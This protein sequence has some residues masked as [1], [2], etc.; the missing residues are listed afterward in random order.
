M[1]EQ[2][3]NYYNEKLINMINVVHGTIQNNEFQSSIEEILQNENYSYAKE[4]SVIQRLFQT[5]MPRERI[6]NSIFLHTANGNY[7]DSLHIPQISNKLEESRV[8]GVMK[9]NTNI[10]WE[11]PQRMNCLKIK[12]ECCLWCLMCRQRWKTQRYSW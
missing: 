1:V 9:K 10:Y 3:A 11:Q 5:I 7:Y 8:F 2:L 12:I 4:L 6:V